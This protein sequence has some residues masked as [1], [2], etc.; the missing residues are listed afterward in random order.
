[1][2]VPV[3]YSV[4]T[5]YVWVFLFAVKLAERGGERQQMKTIREIA[6]EVG[7]SK[8][9]IQK[10]LDKLNLKNE[11]VKKDNKWLI[12]DSVE[13]ALKSAFNFTN[14]NQDGN[15]EKENDNNQVNY[16][17]TLQTIIEMLRTELEEKNKQIDKLQTIINQEQQ[18]RMVTEQKLLAVEKK[19]EEENANHEKKQGFWGRLFGTKPKESTTTDNTDT[20]NTSQPNEDDTT[21]QDGANQ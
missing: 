3:F 10:K 15:K 13:Y 21:H 14:D 18:L 17:N 2:R 20:G 16:D 6:N 9:A 1:M 8:V 11:L 19:G 12:P 4:Y 5:W 7:V